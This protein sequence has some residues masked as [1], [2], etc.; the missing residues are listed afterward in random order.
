MGAAQ[1]D[2]ELQQGGCRSPGDPSTEQ[3]V[4]TPTHESLGAQTLRQRAGI[5]H[6]PCGFVPATFPQCPA[7]QSPHHPHCLLAPLTLGFFGGAS[8]DIKSHPRAAIDGTGPALGHPHQPSQ[9]ESQ[10][11]FAAT[12]AFPCLRLQE[13]LAGSWQPALQCLIAQGLCLPR[14]S[15][16]PRWGRRGC[17]CCPSCGE[18]R[19]CGKSS[20]QKCCCLLASS[21]LLPCARMCAT[22]TGRC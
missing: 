22:G 9:W 6:S 18:G 13:L 1:E 16:P 7:P 11:G 15:L 21:G 5:P 8:L 10:P 4:L 20:A 12:A 19:E 17:F 14:G 3:W 2:A